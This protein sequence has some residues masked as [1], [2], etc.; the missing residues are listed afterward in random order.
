MSV[1]APSPTTSSSRSSRCRWW[2]SSPGRSARSTGAGSSC[3][4][5][6]ARCASGGCASGC[7]NRRA[8]SPVTAAWPK[9]T[10]WSR[11]SNPQALQEHGPLPPL[12]ALLP[13]DEGEGE[14]RG[15]LAA[16]LWPPRHPDVGV[17]FLPDLRLLR[18][19]RLGA[20]AADRQG[21]QHHHQPGIFVHHR[22]RQPDRPGVVHD[23]RRPDGAQMADLSAPRSASACSVCCSPCRIPRLR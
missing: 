10:P 18:L 21:H 20:D 9:P 6:S 11:A 23:V 1:A 2:H 15:N 4:A 17:Q 16:A 8:G 22:H 13:P 5:R 12:G 14:L 19:R 3:S 7:R